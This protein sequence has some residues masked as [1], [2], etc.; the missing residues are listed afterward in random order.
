MVVSEPKGDE[1]RKGTRVP[2]EHPVILEWQTREG[3]IHRARG[4]TRD[5]ALGGV[6]CYLERPLA[7]GTE[8]EFNLVFPAQLA[9]GNTPLKLHC[10]GKTIRSEKAGQRAYGVALSIDSSEVMEALEASVDPG[11]HRIHARIVPPVSLQAEYPGMISAVR[12]VSLAGAFIED[13]RP[14]PV[15]RVFKLRLTSEKLDKEIEVAAVVRR[16]EPHVGMAVEFVALTPE[17]KKTLEEIVAGGRPWR[18]PQE[19]FPSEGWQVAEGQKGTSLN[20]VIEFVRGRAAQATPQLEI[21]ACHYR[22]GSK[23]FSVH[24]RDPVSQ[25]EL[26]LPISERWVNECHAGGD[27]SHMDRALGSASRILDLRSRSG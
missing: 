5:M 9:G 23:V 15:G 16:V 17:A 21:V 27:C 1:R 11:V 4:T 22:A 3:E 13:E 25:A 2:A 12:D 19:A 24:L 7:A 8:V 26:L 14:L 6:Y 10:I 18:G 20:E